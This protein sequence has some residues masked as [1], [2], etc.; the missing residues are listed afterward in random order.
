MAKNGMKRADKVKWPGVYVYEVE[1]PTVEQGGKVRK[2]DSDLS[3]YISYKDGRRKRWEKVGRKSEGMTP[4]VADDIRKQRTL[5]ARHGE[6]VLTARQIK[7]KRAKANRP[8]DEIAQAY[9]DQRGGSAQAAKFDRYRYDLHVK[10][11]LGDRPVSTITEL[12]VRR[13][14]KA[15][16]G[17]AKATV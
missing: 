10:P 15:M 12:D 14:E 16:A 9:F 5:A 2:G 3:Y 4:Q 8:L 7:S 17:K 11:I 13:I 6:E 1:A